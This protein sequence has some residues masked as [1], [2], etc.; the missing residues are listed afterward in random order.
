MDNTGYRNHLAGAVLLTSFNKY[1][2]SSY[3]D[4]LIKNYWINPLLLYVL[5]IN[6]MLVFS[7]NIFVDQRPVIFSTY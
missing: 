3:K 2:T 4:Y 6:N 1:L 5:V 7:S